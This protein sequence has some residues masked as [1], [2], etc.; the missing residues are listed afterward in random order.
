VSGSFSN[1]T[2]VVFLAYVLFLVFIPTRG[3]GI[4][5]LD[6]TTRICRDSSRAAI[7]IGDHFTSRIRKAQS[8]FFCE[9]KVS[10][11]QSPLVTNHLYRGPP[12]RC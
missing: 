3:A 7:S 8:L 6:Y 1:K 9:K 12:M 5:C 2:F 11:K 4:V 10:L